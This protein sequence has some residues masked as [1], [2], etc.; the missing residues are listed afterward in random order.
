MYS[1][2][3]AYLVQNPLDTPFASAENLANVPGS[4]L[5]IGGRTERSD[6]ES[7]L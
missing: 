5:C 3:A 2:T 1:S 4:L 6:L 7:L